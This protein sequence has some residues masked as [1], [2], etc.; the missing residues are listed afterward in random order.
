MVR[1]RVGTGRE[2]GLPSLLDA[3]VGGGVTS[4]AV[5]TGSRAG[6]GLK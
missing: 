6:F 1:G 5:L 2:Q 3:S 4:E